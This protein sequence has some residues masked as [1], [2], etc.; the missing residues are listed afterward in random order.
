MSASS[1]IHH[2]YHLSLA[3]LLGC[4]WTSRAG[5][6]GRLPDVGACQLNPFLIKVEKSLDPMRSGLNT[7][8]S[9]SGSLARSHLR[10]RDPSECSMSQLAQEGLSPAHLISQA[11]LAL[12]G[13]GDT[14]TV[15]S[16]QHHQGRGAARLLYCTSK[17][18]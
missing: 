18:T 15:T 9:A 8:P 5:R 14:H 10:T 1:L 13:R 11:V 17:K 2:V 7:L 3:D 12:D 4:H 16:H 6:T